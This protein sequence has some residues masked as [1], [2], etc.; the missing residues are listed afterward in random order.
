[1]LAAQRQA[2]DRRSPRAALKAKIPKI[3]N[4]FNAAG[5]PFQTKRTETPTNAA[6]PAA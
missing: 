2:V 3:Q 5:T 6:P 1:M 4:L